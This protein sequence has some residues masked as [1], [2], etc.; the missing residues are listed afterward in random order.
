MS[1]YLE[2]KNIKKSFKTEKGSKTALNNINLRIKKNEFLTI[3]GPSGCGKS[4]L[5]K[6][7][8][9]FERADQGQ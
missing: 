3:L 7:I 4:T 2:L 9:G 8:A 1:S 6:I 5:L